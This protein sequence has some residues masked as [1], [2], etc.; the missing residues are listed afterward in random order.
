MSKFKAFFVK[1]KDRMK[2]LG[3]KLNPPATNED[4]SKLEIAVGYIP[5][6]EIKS[7]Y[8]HCNGFDTEDWMFNLLSIEQI[9]CYKSELE[10]PEIYFGEYLIYTDDWRIK[11]EDAN[12]YF[13]TNQQVVLTNS[14]FEFLEVYLNSGGV[15]SENGLYKWFEK[16]N[17]NN[18]TK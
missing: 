14:I 8:A 15:F 11:I 4:I 18:S 9:L 13:I 6:E 5:P 1:H 2:A 12:T 7:F 10:L 16:K 17:N 3:V